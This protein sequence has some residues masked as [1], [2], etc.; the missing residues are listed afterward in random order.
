MASC[1]VVSDPLLVAAID[2]GTTFSGYA[3]A[4]KG[5]YKE[6]SLKISGFTWS[7]GSQAG[8]SL[9]TPT[10]VL[11]NQHGMFDSFGGDAEDKYTSLAEDEKHRNWYF[12]RRFKMQ[13]Y[14]NN[15]SY[16]V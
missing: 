7:L 10:C 8:L 14:R 15:V 9:K 11:F 2:F 5:D 1:E 3:F 6:D 12:F 4:F 16:R 13:L